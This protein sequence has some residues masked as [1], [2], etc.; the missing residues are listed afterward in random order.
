MS[1]QN[2]FTVDELNEIKEALIY[3]KK[4]IAE[5][6]QYP[7]YEFKSAA[8]QKV[9]KILEKVNKIIKSNGK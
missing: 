3:K 7:S 9:E 1:S 6:Q 8:E 4:Y 5:Y 2:V